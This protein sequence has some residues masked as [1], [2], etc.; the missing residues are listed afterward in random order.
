MP[1]ARAWAW[2]WLGWATFLLASTSCPL[3]L[4]P[5]CPLAWAGL[6]GLG[7]LPGLGWAWPPGLASWTGLASC[8]PA[9]RP[10][11]LLGLGLASWPRWACLRALG[12]LG[13]PCALG[14]PP[15]RAGLAC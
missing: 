9:C 7:L 8:L 10:P 3:A 13:W 1:G 11:A 12:L 4:L 2:A 6:P 15:A 14:W 5:S